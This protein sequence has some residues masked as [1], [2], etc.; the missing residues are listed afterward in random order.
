MSNRNH[1][2]FIHIFNI[3]STTTHPVLIN[4]ISQDK[5]PQMDLLN[6]YA[7]LLYNNSSNH[8]YPPI[9]MV[10]ELIIMVTKPITIFIKFTIIYVRIIVE[11]ADNRN[12]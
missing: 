11:L 2:E 9:I 1:G 8:G 7:N 10:K 6:I 3:S 4:E 5:Q 12:V